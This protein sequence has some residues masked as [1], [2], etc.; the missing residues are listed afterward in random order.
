MQLDY[1]VYRC[2][3]IYFVGFVEYDNS[4]G[5]IFCSSEYSCLLIAFCLRGKVSSIVG[6]I[7]MR[8]HAFVHI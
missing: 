2:R 7:V 1:I 3:C 5:H 8:L 6:A 4:G